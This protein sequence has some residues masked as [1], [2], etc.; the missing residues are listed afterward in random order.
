MKWLR[1]AGLFLTASASVTFAQSSIDGDDDARPEQADEVEEYV[2][3]L[4]ESADP[5]PATAPPTRAP[6]P[7][8]AEGP[9]P[10]QVSTI[11]ELLRLIEQGRARDAGNEEGEVDSDTVEPPDG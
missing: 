10:V 6:A 3:E 7:E 8:G 9:P 11:G 5:S 2:R 4:R 1:I